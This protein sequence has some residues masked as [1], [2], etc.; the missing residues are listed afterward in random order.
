MLKVPRHCSPLLKLLQIRSSYEM[1]KQT[2]NSC[3]ACY[4]ALS[5][6]DN[7]D[8]D[9]DDDEEEIEEDDDEDYDDDE[10]EIVEARMLSSRNSARPP[11]TARS[12]KSVNG[13]KTV[14]MT[15]PNRLL[16]KAL[17]LARK[18]ADSKK[19]SILTTKTN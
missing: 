1:H 19:A 16:E 4:D 11:R 5:N 15:P 6:S 17:K 9:D 18:Y 13:K 2:L 10:E 8:H 12:T 14:N 3:Q 7:D